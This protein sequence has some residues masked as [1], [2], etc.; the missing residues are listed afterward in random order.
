MS[1]KKAAAWEWFKK[2]KPSYWKGQVR[3]GAR[4]VGREAAKQIKNEAAATTAKAI[5]DA[6]LAGAGGAAVGALANPDDASSAALRGGLGGIL[7]GVTGSAWAHG[8]GPAA[9]ALL[10]LAGVGMGGSIG[11]L[12]SK[13]KES[14]S[15]GYKYAGVTLDF[16]DDEG[17][18]LKDFFSTPEELP[19][20]IKTASI[21]ESEKLPDEAFALVALDQGHL[22][23]K[24]ACDSKGTTA[25]SVIYFMKHGSKLPESA[26]KTAAANLVNACLQ[27]GLLPPEQLTKTAGQRVEPVVD[28]TG[29]RPRPIVKQAAPKSDDD[30]AVIL[31]NGSRHYPIHSWDMVK[32]ANDYFMDHKS[33]MEPEIRRQFAT[34]L[35]RKAAIISYPIDE[36]IRELGSASY[37]D[38]GQLKSACEMRKCA[39][40]PD[41][42]GRQFLD[43]LFEKRAELRPDTYAEVLRRF[44]LE[45]GLNQG[46]DRVIPNPW[47]STFGVKVASKVLWTSGA[48]RVTDYEL[49]NL[50]RN[51]LE[52]VKQQYSDDFVEEFQK[53]PESVFMS[54]PDPQK[55]LFARM[56]NDASS[57]G[58]SEFAASRAPEGGADPLNSSYDPRS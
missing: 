30:Y 26:Q 47:E 31:S 4:G 52:S 38:D 25:M 19:E 32:K 46:W 14:S 6:S 39:M 57:F 58:E 44:D 20:T 2:M 51:N 8:R 36:T 1:D 16:Y 17:A 12:T 23:R 49:H 5:R 41:S 54:M 45:H 42:E 9:K 43:E 13:K 40:A 10:P 34:K 15:M 29:Q 27:H 53:D 21:K 56:A 37:G 35:A 28:I 24:F 48:E 11:G 50:A 3:K 18:T 33:S 55:K 22:M 7:G